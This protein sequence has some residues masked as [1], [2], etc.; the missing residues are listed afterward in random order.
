MKQILNRIERQLR[1][2]H[3]VEAEDIRALVEHLRKQSE[4]LIECKRAINSLP[5]ESLGVGSLTD[6]DGQEQPYM[7]KHELLQDIENLTQN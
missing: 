3:Y 6:A 5:D 1:D 7:I 4:L 2:N